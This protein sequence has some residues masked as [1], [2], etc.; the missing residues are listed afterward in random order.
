M[1]NLGSMFEKGNGFA[2]DSQ[3]AVR[4]Y[5][6]AAQAGSTSAMYDLGAMYE[7]G[8]GVGKDRQQAVVW[9]RKAA[10]LGEP[11]AK[12]SLNRLGVTP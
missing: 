11:H 12:D 4:W 6:K 2:K 8:E 10:V 3:Q 1:A 9:Y 5:V 7:S